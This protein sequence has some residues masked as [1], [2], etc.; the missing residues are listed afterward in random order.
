MENIAKAHKPNKKELTGVVV[1]DKMEKTVVVKV[2]TKVLHP[3]YKKYVAQSKKYKAHDEKN[4]AK[5]G[6]TVRIIECRPVSKDKCW[7]LK[8][9][10][11]KAK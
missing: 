10:I 5:S 3:L 8:E 7:N 2:S 9:I 11:E 4:E 1:S 6:D